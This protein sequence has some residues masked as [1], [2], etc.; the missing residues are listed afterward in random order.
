[1]ELMVREG[2]K[3]LRLLKRRGEAARKDGW[4]KEKKL[5]LIYFDF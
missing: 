5:Y 4:G 2:R 3:I 1:M